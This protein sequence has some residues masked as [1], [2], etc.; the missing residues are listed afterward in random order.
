MAVRVPSRQVAPAIR[1]RIVIG[2]IEILPAQLAIPPSGASFI[3]EKKIFRNRIRLIPRPRKI[4]VRPP[5]R[6]VLDRVLRKMRQR[7]TSRFVQDGKGVAVS[8][9]FV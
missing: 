6:S 9:I 1:E 4:L 8:D 7:R 5:R 3:R 2:R